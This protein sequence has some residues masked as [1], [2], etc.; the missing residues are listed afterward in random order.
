MN[1]TKIKE[2]IHLPTKLELLAAVF[3]L[4]LA[5]FAGGFL[6]LIPVI[7]WLILSLFVPRE[8]AKVQV[9]CLSYPIVESGLKLLINNNV[10]PYSWEL[11]NRVE[12]T[13][14]SVCLTALMWFLL[15]FNTNNK[16]SLL[17]K[18]LIVVGIVVVIGNFN[19][20]WEA[21]LRDVFVN[22]DISKQ[23]AYYWD[24]IIDMVMNLLGSSLMV[25]AFVVRARQK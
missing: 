8:N 4:V 18:G 24:T 21:F 22:P 13:M 16:L 2:L 6:W 17:Y 10:I 5:Y 25:L 7:C 14:F 3:L 23:A 19:E 9:L 1:L 15:R 11:L 20:F 12:H